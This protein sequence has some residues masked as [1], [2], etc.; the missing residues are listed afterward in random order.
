MDAEQLTELMLELGKLA[1]YDLQPGTKK[2]DRF[3]K[4][5]VI[6]EQYQ[7]NNIIMP[8]VMMVKPKLDQKYIQ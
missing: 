5:I 6:C 2:F 1:E 8:G 3:C 4:L 7:A